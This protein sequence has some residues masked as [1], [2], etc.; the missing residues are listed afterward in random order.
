MPRSTS[1][2]LVAKL[3]Q[4][5]KNKVLKHPHTPI[6]S[7]DNKKIKQDDQW[8]D[9]LNRQLYLYNNLLHL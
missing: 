3:Q 6:S 7:V 4:K 2:S 8:H 1:S 9:L 5:E